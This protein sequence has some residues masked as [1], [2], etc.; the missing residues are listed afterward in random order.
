MTP[1]PLELFVWKWQSKVVLAGYDILFAYFVV[2]PK[3]KNCNKEVYS[4]L[5]VI[6]ITLFLVNMFFHV[7]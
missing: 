1:M 7:L 2:E 6:K 5:N 4:L 3:S